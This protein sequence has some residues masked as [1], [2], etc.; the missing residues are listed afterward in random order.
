[1]TGDFVKGKEAVSEELLAK[2]AMVNDT[3]T[4]KV[5]YLVVGSKGIEAWKYGNYDGKVAKAK[6]YNAK[7]KDIK[8]VSEK[9][10]TEALSKIS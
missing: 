7:V 4:M 1:M 3:L 6:E 2:G 5:N 10:L 8:I 9:A